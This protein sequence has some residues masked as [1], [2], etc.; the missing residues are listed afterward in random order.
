M[1]SSAAAAAVA[2][3]TT[4][5]TSS[6]HHQFHEL[7]Q[8]HQQQQQLQ[9]NRYQQELV[10]S[11]LNQQQQQSSLP[12]SLLTPVSSCHSLTMAQCA[13]SSSAA[14]SP[15]HFIE[16]HH[17]HHPTAAN[18]VSF[19]ARL[20]SL[21]PYE[22]K[23][24][25]ADN[26]LMRRISE[27]Q[28]LMESRLLDLKGHHNSISHSNATSRS[29]QQQQQQQ[30]N[31]LYQQQ[32]SASLLS[33]LDLNS[34]QPLQE[35]H[36]RSFFLASPNNH[37]ANNNNNNNN[38]NDYYQNYYAHQL[39]FAQHQMAQQ[40]QQHHEHQQLYLL[41]SRVNNYHHNNNN[42]N[43][44][45]NVNSANNNNKDVD[46]NDDS[47]SQS[48][49]ATS[50]TAPSV[51]SNNNSNNDKNNKSN[52]NNIN[53][54]NDTSSNKRPNQP[55]LDL[56]TT[57]TRQVSVS[58]LSPNG[59][60]PN[61]R[62]TSAG[63]G[64]SSG[65]VNVNKQQLSP[66]SYQQHPK[67]MKLSQY[68]R[69]N[70]LD[71]NHHHQS[72]SNWPDS[73][74][75]GDQNVG[76]SSGD[77]T[78]QS[79]ASLG[80]LGG[81]AAEG[82][83]PAP[84]FSSSSSSSISEFDSATSSAGPSISS[85]RNSDCTTKTTNNTSEG[86]ALSGEK[87]EPKKKD[88]RAQLGNG[89]LPVSESEGLAVAA[90]ALAE[91]SEQRANQS[92]NLRTTT[93]SQQQQ[94]PSVTVVDGIVAHGANNNAKKG[95]LNGAASNNNNI[96]NNNNNGNVRGTSNNSKKYKCEFDE[97]SPAEVIER[98]LELNKPDH[99]HRFAVERGEC[100]CV[101]G[102][103][104]RDKTKQEALQLLENWRSLDAAERIKYKWD[105][106]DLPKDIPLSDIKKFEDL[107][108]DFSLGRADFGGAS[109]RKPLGIRGTRQ[110]L[111]M[112][113]CLW[114]H[115]G[116][117]DQM[118]QD[119][120]CPHCFA[121]IRTENEQSTLVR[122]VNH[123]NMKHRRGANPRLSPRLEAASQSTSLSHMSSNS[124]SSSPMNSSSSGSKVL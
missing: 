21:N 76:S 63:S 44:N 119:G 61:S 79:G 46:T 122:V 81:P 97:P 124:S 69:Q 48:G 114:G 17:H 36:Q 62:T 117:E 5:D 43:I 86:S 41:S 57:P 94:A 45:N 31:K 16:A 82:V 50:N 108:R 111:L 11:Y 58:P 1:I 116:R 84:S 67:K 96:N 118:Q 74:T 92:V 68:K 3:A 52:N 32:I 7:H 115:P 14:S 19:A 70:N 121:R 105:I 12:S 6:Y 33:P 113:Y 103:E 106:N 75:N 10:K 80:G 77:H 85:K 89:G 26:E 22:L 9:A 104:F 71:A 25:N 47:K 123:F 64:A 73:Q 42:N 38:N 39:L 88:T 91:L 53:N 51:T 66:N 4:N 95:P 90:A 83:S 99:Y 29:I 27:T 37:Q 40:I 120:Y 56:R 109:K 18:V 8:Q 100:A 98:Q 65:C 15:Q 49:P 60:G 35:Q 107:R 2:A 54:N 20:M 78:Q 72:A 55:A 23:C 28:S 24:L 30:L 101:I 34:K 59:G 102:S 110:F 93:M 13:S 112:L 87:S